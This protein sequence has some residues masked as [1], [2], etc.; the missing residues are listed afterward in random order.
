MLLLENLCQLDMPRVARDI[1]LYDINN[2]G[3]CHT[4]TA[5]LVTIYYIQLI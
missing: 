4:R 3:N 1:R 5:V 2:N